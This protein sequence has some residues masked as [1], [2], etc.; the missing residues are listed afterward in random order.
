[1]KYL[2]KKQFDEHGWRKGDRVIFEDS[3]K[4]IRNELVVYANVRNQFVGTTRM[5]SVDRK[6]IIE[7]IPKGEK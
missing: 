2:T 4:S 1:M 5:M 7:I 3:D 6:G